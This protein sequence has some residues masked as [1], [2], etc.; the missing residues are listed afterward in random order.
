MTDLLRKR[1]SEINILIGENKQIML[2]YVQLESLSN[3]VSY[4]PL[5]F[6]RGKKQSMIWKSTTPL[7]CLRKTNKYSLLS[8][9]R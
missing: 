3:H 2:R 9:K 6:V 8:N 4:Y 7:S 5:P 1:E